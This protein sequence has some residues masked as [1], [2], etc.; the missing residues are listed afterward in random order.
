MA[1][2]LSSFPSV[3]VRIVCERCER[4]G[5][6]R[7]ARLAHRF[8]PEAQVRDVLN[9]LTSTCQHRTPA[10]HCT[11]RVAADGLSVPVDPPAAVKAATLA[12]VRAGKQPGTR[13]TKRAYEKHDMRTSGATIGSLAEAGRPVLVTARCFAQGCGHEAVIDVS[14]WRQEIF[15]RDIGLH[16]RCMKCGVRGPV[17]VRSVA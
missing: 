14:E 8:G 12:A 16:L 7:L 1:W 2:R 13:N 10:S 9:A 4:E 5:R 6:Y 17:A 11:A 15:V 3:T